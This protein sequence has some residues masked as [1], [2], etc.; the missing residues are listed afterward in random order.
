MCLAV[1]VSLAV[2]LVRHT[3]LLITLVVVGAILPVLVTVGLHYVNRATGNHQLAAITVR[4]PKRS[5]RSFVAL[6]LAAV[7]LASFFIRRCRARPSHRWCAA[8]GPERGA[9]ALVA[10]FPFITRF[11]GPSATLARFD[12]PPSAGFPAAAVDVMT[13]ANLA[14]VR[15]YEYAVW[16]PTPTPGPASVPPILATGPPQGPGQCI[17]MPTRRRTVR[18]GTGMP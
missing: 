3:T 9:L 8:T 12:V 14:A 6:A 5:P 2:L 7:V 10:E 1:G 16:Y 4:F 18:R 11:L 17:A 13:T 15:D